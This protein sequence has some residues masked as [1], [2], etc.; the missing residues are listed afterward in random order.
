MLAERHA[1][2][3]DGQAFALWVDADK[4]LMRHEVFFRREWDDVGFFIAAAHAPWHHMMT[5]NVPD[6]LAVSG[7]FDQCVV[8]PLVVHT[9]NSLPFVHDWQWCEVVGLNRRQTLHQIDGVEH[10][11]KLVVVR[12]SREAGHLGQEV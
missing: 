12:A 7:T 4:Q 11:V 6:S 8:V 10:G 2:D 5:L 3:S 1:P 9:L